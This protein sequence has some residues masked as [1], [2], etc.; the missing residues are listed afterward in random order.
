MNAKYAN[1]PEVISTVKEI[2]KDGSDNLIGDKVTGIQVQ[3][4]E[5]EKPAYVQIYIRD[6]KKG[7]SM[8]VEIELSELVSALSLASLNAERNY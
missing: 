1:C 3:V 7:S 6:L 8:V 4:D 5:K 2:T